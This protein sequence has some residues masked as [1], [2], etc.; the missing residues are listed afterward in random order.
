MAHIE[1]FRG[2]RPRKDIAHLVAAPPYDVLSSEEAREMAAGN[3][4]CF[5]HVGKPEIDLPPGTDPYSDDVY[6]KGRENFRHF[7]A[8][9]TIFQDPTKD[10]Y[11]YKQVWGETMTEL[12]TRTMDMHIAKL[13]SK[14][15]QDCAEPQ[16]IKTV[17]G[18]GYRYEK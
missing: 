2:V 12:G 13:R 16:I 8:E 6:A 4:L 14:I 9:G 11:V 18:A 5:L 17:R 15:E 10:F 1:P 7:L 3:P